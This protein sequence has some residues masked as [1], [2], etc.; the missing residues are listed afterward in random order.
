MYLVFEGVMLH[1]KGCLAEL[2]EIL[3]DAGIYLPAKVLALDTY[4]KSIHIE[5]GQYSIMYGHIRR[6]CVNEKQEKRKT[7]K[8]R[9]SENVA[10]KCHWH[11]ITVVVLAQGFPPNGPS[12][13]GTS[14][15]PRILLCVSQPHRLPRAQQQALSSL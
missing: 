7:N 12:Y 6:A 5:C 3:S 10:S 15:P 2:I 4:R 1:R 14:A 9:I 13:S 11:V 8:T